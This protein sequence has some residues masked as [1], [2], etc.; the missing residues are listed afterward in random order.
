MQKSGV[1][2]PDNPSISLAV[3][4]F[5]LNQTPM[6]PM[7]TVAVILSRERNGRSQDMTILKRLLS[8]GFQTRSDTNHAVQPHKIVTGLK[9]LIWEVEGLYFLCYK[10]K[11]ADQLC[12]YHA[13]YLRLCFHIIM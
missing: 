5:I 7:T 8:S 12:S 13:A 3:A 11:G 10:N 2:R 1:Q 6:T 9:F 4:V